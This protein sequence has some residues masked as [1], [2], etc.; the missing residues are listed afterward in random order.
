MKKRDAKLAKR[1]IETP[2]DQIQAEIEQNKIL[3]KQNEQKT[4]K[5]FYK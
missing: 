1:G 3:Q 5:S 2:E 4:V